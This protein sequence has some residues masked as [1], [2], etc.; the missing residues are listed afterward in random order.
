MTWMKTQGTAV[1]ATSLLSYETSKNRRMTLLFL[2]IVH[3]NSSI[4]HIFFLSLCIL[5]DWCIKTASFFAKQSFPV[6]KLQD[7]IYI[8]YAKIFPFLATC[9]AIPWLAWT[10]GL[11]WLHCLWN[12]IYYWHI[13]FTS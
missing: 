11:V 13:G 5:K 9:S 10:H 3:A 1:S 7:F 6:T 8:T 4:I 12:Q 2:S